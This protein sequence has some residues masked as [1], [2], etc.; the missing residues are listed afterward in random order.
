M[1]PVEDMVNYLLCFYGEPVFAACGSG[2]LQFFCAE[3][4]GTGKDKLNK[5]AA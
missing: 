1:R 2:A 5:A 3:T 4:T